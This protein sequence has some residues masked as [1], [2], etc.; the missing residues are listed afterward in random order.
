FTKQLQLSWLKIQCCRSHT[1]RQCYENL[2]EA[3]GETVLPY[4]TVA[5]WVRVFNE[6]RESVAEVARPGRPRVSDKQVQAVA[7]LLDRHSLTSDDILRTVE[8]SQC[9]RKCHSAMEQRVNIKF[10]YKLGKTATETHGMLVQVYGREA[11][12]R[13]CVYEWFKR[14]REGK[15]TIEDEQRSGRPSTSRTPEMIEKGKRKICSR[16]VP[17][18]LTD[19]QKTKRIETSGDFISMCEQDPLLLKTI[20]TSAK[21]SPF[22]AAFKLGNRK[23]SAGARSG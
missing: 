4:R 23:K 15:E 20:V 16:F 17:H 1:A 3:C 7:A 6:G 11:V 10:C 5:R 18:K 2:V 12:S 14:F 21:R 13:K 9:E 19:E 22:M 8:R